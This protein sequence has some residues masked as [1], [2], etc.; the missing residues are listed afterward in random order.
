MITNYSVE[1][2]ICISTVHD[3]RFIYFI[4]NGRYYEEYQE[5]FKS[6]GWRTIGQVKEI[7][8]EDYIEATT[9]E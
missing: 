7:C 4:K 8:K 6:C 3:S 9:A 5:Y 1:A 2:I